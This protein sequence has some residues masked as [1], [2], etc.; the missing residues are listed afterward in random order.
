[1]ENVNGIKFNRIDIMD[2]RYAD[3]GGQKKE[4]AEDDR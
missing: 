4:S 2:L 1:M 3:G